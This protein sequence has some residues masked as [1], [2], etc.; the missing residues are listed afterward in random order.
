MTL[1][2]TTFSK[3]D[4]K[5][6]DTQHNDNQHDDTQRDDIKHNGLNC[7]SQHKIHSA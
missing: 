3:Q 6:N 4:T 7:D 1:S 2:I 5:H